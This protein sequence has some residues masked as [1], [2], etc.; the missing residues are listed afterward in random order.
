MD[1]PT[2]TLIMIVKNESKIIERCLNSVKDYVDYIVISDTGST[3]NTPEI[4]ECYLSKNNIRGTVYRDQWENFGYNRTKSLTNGQDWLD[5]QNIEKTKNYFIT[6]DADMILVFNNFN[7][8]QLLEKQ[9]W[10][11]LQMNNSIK[12]YNMRIFRSDL[13]YRCI[14]VT[15]EY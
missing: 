14:G 5:K 11:L 9:S 3:D 13:S 15:H 6:I 12:Y 2:L 7:K 1:S 10:S 8:K 4:I